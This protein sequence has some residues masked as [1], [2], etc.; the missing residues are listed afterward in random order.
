MA[1]LIK[2]KLHTLPAMASDG[3]LQL[4][5]GRIVTKM[6]LPCW[7]GQVGAV[8]LTGL[9]QAGL[10]GFSIVPFQPRDQIEQTFHS[11]VS[12]PPAYC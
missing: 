2:E 6:T 7:N 12:I 3:N 5:T 1:I 9:G 11:E 10:T 4:R 8:G